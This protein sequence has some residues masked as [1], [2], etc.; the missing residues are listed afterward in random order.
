MGDWTII[1]KTFKGQKCFPLIF[2]IPLCLLRDRSVF[3]WFLNFKT[4]L[5]HL[6]KSVFRW[7]S[8]F[9]CALYVGDWT[10]IHQTSPHNLHTWQPSPLTAPVKTTSQKKRWY[11]NLNQFKCKPNQTWQQ[12]KPNPKI[13]RILKISTIC[14]PDPDKLT[15]TNKFESSQKSPWQSQSPSLWQWF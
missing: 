15:E 9:P 4:S 7:F 8:V 1:H 11:S 13:R 12:I 3:H 10:I 6:S 2:S 5:P 14:R